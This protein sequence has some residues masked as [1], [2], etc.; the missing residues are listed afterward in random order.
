MKEAVAQFS[1]AK[2]VDDE[3]WDSFAQG[4][5]YQPVNIDKPEDYKQLSD[6]LDQIDRERGTQG[7]RVFYLSTAPSLYAEA[8]KQLGEAG[9]ANQ[10]HGLD[11]RHHREAVRH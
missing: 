7:N 5:Y 10:D 3:V 11:A 1:E 8:V 6:L 4:L 9:L 2:R